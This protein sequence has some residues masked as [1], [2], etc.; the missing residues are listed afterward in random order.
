MGIKQ[1]CILLFKQDARPRYRLMAFANLV[2]TFYVV[3]MAAAGLAVGFGFVIPGVYVKSRNLVLLHYAIAMFLYIN[4]VGNYVQ[5][6]R[7]EST[8]ETYYR[9]LGSCG[10]VRTSLRCKQC[11]MKVPARCHHCVLCNRCVVK[12]DH[13]CYFMSTCIGYRNHG[14]F[15]CFCFYTFIAAAYSCIHLLQYLSL[16]IQINDIVDVL[17]LGP[18]VI[19]SWFLAA[20]AP[21][22][23]ITTLVGLFYGSLGSGVSAGGFFFIHFN[24]ISKGLTTFEARKNILINS[25][26]TW[27]QNFAEVLGPQWW[28]RILLPVSTP[29]I[30]DIPRKL[31]IPD[32]RFKLSHSMNR[33]MKRQF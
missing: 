20:K 14:Y 10:N 29:F 15:L 28:C 4:V 25:S 2:G 17:T 1:M 31:C 23:S 21:S 32:D 18:R 16:Y 12:R 9:R 7:H 13:H 6:C 5:S 33:R 26:G 27:L 22:T 8:L 30:S 3:L 19:F 11:K 24:L